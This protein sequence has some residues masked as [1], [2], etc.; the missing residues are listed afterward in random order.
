MLRLEKQVE[1]LT[2]DLA[3]DK[4]EWDER[5]R[6]LRKE[7]EARYQEEN[8]ALKQEVARLRQIATE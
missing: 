5:E 8:R 7:E 3:K 4:R 6:Q 2:L 1:M